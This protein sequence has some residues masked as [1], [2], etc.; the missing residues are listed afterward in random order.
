[1]NGKQAKML[2]KLG[3]ESHADKRQFYSLP[4]EVKALLR[5]NV[6]LSASLLLESP[7]EKIDINPESINGNV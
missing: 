2:R 1:M 3:R 4:Q 7:P 5:Q 6:K